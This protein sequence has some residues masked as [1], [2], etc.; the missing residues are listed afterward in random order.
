MTIIC[1]NNQDSS[2]IQNYWRSQSMNKSHIMSSTE[3]GKGSHGQ[4]THKN[5]NVEIKTLFYASRT[6]LVIFNENI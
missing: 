4:I 6:C 2:F 5:T 3:D 1:A